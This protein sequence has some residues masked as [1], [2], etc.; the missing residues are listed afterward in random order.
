[1]EMYYILYITFKKKYKKYK[2]IVNKMKHI[3]YNKGTKSIKGNTPKDLK[4]DL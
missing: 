4:N 3:G 2:K 1:M